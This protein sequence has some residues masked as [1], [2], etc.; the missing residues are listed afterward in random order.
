MVGGFVKRATRFVLLKMNTRVAKLLA[1]LLCIPP[2][3]AGGEIVD[4]VVAVV[5]RE[6]ITETELESQFL[7]YQAQLGLGPGE[8]EETEKLRREVLETMIENRILYAQ[9]EKETLEV[10]REEVESALETAV[11]QMRERFASEEEFQAQ[12]ER[13]RLTLEGLKGRHRE[14]MRRSLL[15]QKLIQKRLTP[16]VSVTH[17]DV[18]RFYRESPDSVL[19]EPATLRL[20]HVLIPV[21]PS[22]ETEQTARRR[23]QEILSA[24]NAG[25]SFSHL[26]RERSDDSGTRD[27]GGDLGY[28]K[29]GEMVPEFEQAAFSL[30]AGEMTVI[31][32][33]FGYHIIRAEGKR[34]EEVRVRHILVRVAATRGDTLRARDLAEKAKERAI[35]GEDFASLV[36]EYSQDPSSKEMG[37]ELGTFAAGELP[38]A[39]A[40]AVGELETGEIGGPVMTEFGYHVLKVLD[41]KEARTPSFGEIKERLKAYLTQKRMEEE[42]QKWI[43]KLKEEIYLEN[44]LR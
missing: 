41:K 33:R 26:A 6:V 37:G 2:L 43:S 8:L 22:E 9:A 21:V 39:F 28:F 25:A 15:V 7:L 38:P 42:Y 32:S 40:E 5:G 10:T 16:R 27:K 17:L 20:A 44:R 30:A 36:E 14:E 35:S 4:Q 1:F 18:E 24:I 23:V 34:D 29:R 19:A 11:S 13:E 31:R 3:L 12:L